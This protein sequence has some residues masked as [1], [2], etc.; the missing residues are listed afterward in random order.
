MGGKGK[1][2]SVRKKDNVAV[3]HLN[4]RLANGGVAQLFLPQRM[5]LKSSWLQA[6]QAQC[7]AAS[8]EVEGRDTSRALNGMILNSHRFCIDLSPYLLLCRGA[9]V[10]YIV[11]SNVAQYIEFKSLDKMYLASGTTEGALKI[12]PVPCTKSDVFKS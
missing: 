5:M 7:T 12:K 8:R 3:V 4:W 6:I 11:Q 9:S 2:W 10:N 1:L